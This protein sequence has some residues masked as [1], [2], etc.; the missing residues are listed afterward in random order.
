LTGPEEKTEQGA[1]SSSAIAPPPEAATTPQPPTLCDV[2]SHCE[3]SL[4]VRQHGK[5]DLGLGGHIA[6]AAYDLAGIQEAEE[7]RGQGTSAGMISR[8]REHPVVRPSLPCT[9]AAGRMRASVT[10]AAQPAAAARGAHLRARGLE[11]RALL[12]VPV[13]HDHLVSRLQQV[14]GLRGAPGGGGGRLVGGARGSVGGGTPR[15][16]RATGRNNCTRAFAGA[17]RG[18]PAAPRA[19]HCQA[20]DADAH[21]AERGGARLSGGYR[22]CA[23]AHSAGRPRR[24]Q[25]DLVAGAQR[26]AVRRHAHPGETWHPDSLVH[27]RQHIAAIPG[28]AASAG[29]GRSSAQKGLHNGFLE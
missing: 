24:C 16:G 10:A 8:T 13:P 17:L 21:K 15:G 3:R 5:G 29:S 19:H 9:A 1:G 23:H 6:C 12:G 18:R 7:R 26:C 2:V 25:H 11:R 27:A 20:H 14:V 4:W 22:G 28:K